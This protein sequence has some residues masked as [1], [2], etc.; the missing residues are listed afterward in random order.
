MKMRALQVRCDAQEVVV[1]RLQS[2][3]ASNSEKTKK[4]K[5]ALHLLNGEVKDHKAQLQ[6]R[7]RWVEKLTKTNTN[8]T[9]ELAALYEQVGKAKVDAVEEY[10][11]SQPYFDEL[12]GQYGEGFED[13]CKQVVAFLLGLDFSQIQIN[14]RVPMTPSG[15]NHA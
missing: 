4:F 3:M 5:E 1:K 2:S 12:G 8:L 14:T 11:Y 15:P 7:A 6:G 10:K 13:F 9:T